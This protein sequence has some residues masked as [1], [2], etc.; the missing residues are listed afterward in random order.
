MKSVW[1]F[2]EYIKELSKN[3]H[4]IWTEDFIQ[5]K[6]EFKCGSYF[7]RDLFW[8]LFSGCEK[9]DLEI[10]E[11]ISLL[12]YSFNEAVVQKGQKRGTHL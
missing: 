9:D 6:T 7:W 2:P 11:G 3:F 8:C 4:V 5:H 12:V 10:L 1:I